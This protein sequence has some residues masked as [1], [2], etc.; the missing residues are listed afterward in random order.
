MPAETFSLCVERT[1]PAPREAVF[2]AW[3][4]P[5]QLKRW[6]RPGP[7]GLNVLAEADPRVGGRFRFEFAGPDGHVYV[8]EGAYR[9]VQEPERLVYGCRFGSPGWIEPYE[10][11]VTVAFEALGPATRVEVRGDGYPRADDRDA[12]QQGWPAFLGELAA[13]FE[14]SPEIRDVE[15]PDAMRDDLRAAWHRY[16]DRVAPFRPAL[17]GYCRRLTGNLWDAEDLV[18]DALLRAFATLGSIHESIENPRAYLLR[19]ATNLWIDAVRRRSREATALA[20]EAHE[21]AGSPETA[22]VVR[23]AGATLLQRL[24]PQERAAVVLKEAF[25]MS[26]GEIAGVLATSVGAVKSALHRGR[27]RLRE[28][29]DGS[30]SRRPVPSAALVDRF[31]ALFNAK[32]KAGLIAL[33]LDAGQVENV[34]CSVAYGP[35]RSFERED[36]WF[37]KAVYGHPEWPAVFRYEASRLERVVFEG[38]PLM[39]GLVTRWGNEALEQVLRIEE[40]DAAIARLRGYAFCPETIRAVG[41]A[42]GLPV[43]TGLY[44]YPTPAPGARFPMP[45][46]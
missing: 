44:R 25:D 14:R 20:A 40:Q 6:M 10:T 38:E 39:L 16:L 24:A 31:V 2:R 8:E 1:V 9:E 46:V 26:L 28:P 7:E 19:T 18:Q 43:R 29:E 23:D 30:A 13:L 42:L 5:A 41:A 22:R 4:D 21:E 33:M 45:E 36:G 37:H 35:R 3:T 27:E 12:H 34:G 17:H 11:L 15:L 32:D